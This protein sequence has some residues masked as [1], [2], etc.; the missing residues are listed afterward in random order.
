MLNGLSLQAFRLS[1]NGDNVTVPLPKDFITTGDADLEIAGRRPDNGGELGIAMTGRVAAK[2][3]LY[4]KDI[5]LS[6]I[7]G[8]RRDQPIHSDPL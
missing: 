8:A 7:V 5:D 6:S 4:S 3:S 1:V 2:R